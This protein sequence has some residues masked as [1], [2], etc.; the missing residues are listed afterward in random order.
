MNHSMY[1]LSVTIIPHIKLGMFHI[2]NN[3]S[4]IQDIENNFLQFQENVFIFSN[5]QSNCCCAVSLKER[6]YQ[7]NLIGYS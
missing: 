6:A 4:I 1:R 2:N 7:T 3:L 5:Q